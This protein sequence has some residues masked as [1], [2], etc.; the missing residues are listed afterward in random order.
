MMKKIAIALGAIV[1]LLLVFLVYNGA[2]QKLEVVRTKSEKYKLMGLYH[3]G[4]YQKIGEVFKKIAVGCEKLG[5]KDSTTDQ[6]TEKDRVSFGVYFDNPQEKKEDSLRSFA[7]VQ[8]FTT[9]DSL[10]FMKQF[11]DAKY[12]EIQAGNALVVEQN[13]PNMAAMIIA[14]MRAYPALHQYLN[15][16]PKEIEAAKITQVYEMYVPKKTHFVMCWKD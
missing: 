12:Y 6:I 2:F 7:G 10:A 14:I 5:W 8:I 4:S 16:H 13:T 9:E 15:D 1:L 11:P 3:Q